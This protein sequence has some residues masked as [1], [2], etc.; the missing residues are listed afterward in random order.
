[1][2]PLHYTL[3]IIYHTKYL[4]ST[5]TAFSAIIVLPCSNNFPSN[6]SEFG[7]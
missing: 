3:H 1:M 5:S 2:L 4:A 7:T 6:K